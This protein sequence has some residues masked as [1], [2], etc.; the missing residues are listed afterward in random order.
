METIVE[1]DLTSAVKHHHQIYKD[2]D[3]HSYEH[4]Q[5]LYWNLLQIYHQLTLDYKHVQNTIQKTVTRLEKRGIVLYSFNNSFY[6]QASQLPNIIDV[7]LLVF[8]SFRYE[9][10]EISN[11]VS[12]EEIVEY[13][14]YFPGA[15]EMDHSLLA[16]V[17]FSELP[18]YITKAMVE[19]RLIAHQKQAENRLLLHLEEEKI[20]KIQQRLK[21]ERKR[22]RKKIRK[23]P[24][25]NF[26]LSEEI[27]VPMKKERN[28]DRND[29]S[30]SND[31]K[32][33][34]AVKA[35]DVSKEELGK[36]KPMTTP[37]VFEL[38]KTK[39]EAYGISHSKLDQKKYSM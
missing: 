14:Y 1:I 25:V 24:E 31:T 35:T 9:P 17:V 18:N 33:V 38:F 3:Q 36:T 22:R 13:L 30:G 7:L 19:N 10:D 27:H 37:T 26:I 32:E 29:C 12:V 4:N 5:V 15:K 20:R 21:A 39:L 11:C 6:I 34:N 16:S 28:S 8:Y 23:Q 2:I